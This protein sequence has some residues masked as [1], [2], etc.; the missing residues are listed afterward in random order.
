MFISEAW[1]QTAETAAP[2]G[3]VSGVL[4]QLGLIF[5]IFYFL[6]IR[7]QQKKIKQHE[8]MLAAIKKGDKILTGGGV[9]AKVLKADDPLNLTVELAPNMVVEVNRATVRDVI[10]PEVEAAAA[11]LRK[12]EQKKQSKKK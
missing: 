2:G 7:P 12:N 6:L 5:I 4:I 11:E 9:Y 3:S 10:T 1:A 8:T